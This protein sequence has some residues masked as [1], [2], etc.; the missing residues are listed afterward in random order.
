MRR[1]LVRIDE[2]A[3]AFHLG[4]LQPEGA[5]FRLN[6]AQTEALAGL[7]PALGGF[8]PFLLHGGYGFGE[9]GGLS[10]GDATGAGTGGWRRFLLVPEI[11]L[12]PQTAGLLDAVFG[13]RVALLHSALTPEE[14]SEQWRRIRRG[15]APIVVGDAVGHLCACAKSGFDPGG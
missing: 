8:K 10:G 7:V 11:G 3:A 15:D 6:G 4:G 14:R 12:T 2:R 13:S 5:P 9:D 1:G